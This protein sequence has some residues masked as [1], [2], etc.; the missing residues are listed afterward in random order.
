MT[1]RRFATAGLGALACAAGLGLAAP[2]MAAPQPLVLAPTFTDVDVEDDD[3]PAKTPLACKV[4][5]TGLADARRDPVS[6]GTLGNRA[7]RSPADTQA[8]MR[9]VLGGLPRRGVAPQFVAPDAPAPDGP[10]AKFTLRMVWV[11]YVAVDLSANVVVSVD[12]TADN[13]RTLH[14]TYRGRVARMNWA[15]TTSEIQ[16]A[17]NTAFAD[18]LD[19]MAPD[20]KSLCEAKV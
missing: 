12:A 20:L 19:K 13:G 10:A 3:T 15:S 1:P 6:V 2:A 16:S 8:W 7:I 4:T 17:V 14:Q 11:D 18:V 5:F 9:A